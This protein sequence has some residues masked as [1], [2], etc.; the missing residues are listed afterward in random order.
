[1]KWILPI[2]SLLVGAYCIFGFMATFE[3]GAANAMAFRIGYA[4]MGLLCLAGILLP[5]FVRK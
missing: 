4:I 2:A 5:L 3:P 1:M